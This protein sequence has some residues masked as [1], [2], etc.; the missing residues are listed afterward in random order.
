[1]AT[2]VLDTEIFPQHTITEMI[3]GITYVVQSAEAFTLKGNKHTDTDTDTDTDTHTHTHTHTHT[4]TGK[5]TWPG[6]KK[7]SH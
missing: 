5:F 7:K 2:K 1:M 3:S 6:I 4:L